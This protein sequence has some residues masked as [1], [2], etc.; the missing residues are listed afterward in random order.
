MAPRG[1]GLVAA[2]A[3]GGASPARNRTPSSAPT[4]IPALYNW[5]AGPTRFTLGESPEIVV[6][7]ARPLLS[8]PA[9]L[10]AAEVKALTGVTPTVTTGTAYDALTGD[11]HLALDNPELPKDAYWLNVRGA[12]TISGSSDTGVFH[13]TRTVGQLLGQSTT[14]PGGSSTDAPAYPERS[15]M[16]DVARKY[17]SIGFLKA[18]IRELAWLKYNMLHLHLTDTQA[19]RI[20]CDTHP[21][22]VAEKHYSKAE[23]ADLVS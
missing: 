6:A 23:M 18:L 9:R 4:V 13:G 5:T 21:A 20:E 12:L 17:Y 14:I 19:Y 2:A 15:F 7:G 16:L 11:I 1:W 3:C 8:A 22:A 10:F